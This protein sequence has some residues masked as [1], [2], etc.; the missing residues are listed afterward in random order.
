M[1]SSR[2]AKV[3]SGTFVAGPEPVPAGGASVPAAEAPGKPDAYVAIPSPMVGTFYAAPD[4]ESP[5]YVTVEFAVQ[6]ETVVCIVEAMK[7]MNEIKA[8]AKGVITAALIEN[9][10]PVEFGQPLFKLRPA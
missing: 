1:P 6:P 3:V 9:A 10:K 7:V 5:P 8:E 4:A 2:C